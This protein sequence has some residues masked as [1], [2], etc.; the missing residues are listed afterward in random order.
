MI[1]INGF[2]ESDDDCVLFTP[3]PAAPASPIPVP[4]SPD[5]VPALPPAAVVAPAAA[6]AGSANLWFAQQVKTPANPAQPDSDEDSLLEEAKQSN[7]MLPAM[8]GGQK[9]ATK[10]GKGKRKIMRN[11]ATPRSPRTP[12][13]KKQNK[14]KSS[15]TQ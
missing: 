2:D 12:K 10:D 8:K 11:T 9:K 3:P 6:P 7:G 14:C 5:V 1:A 4:A 15:T 13:S